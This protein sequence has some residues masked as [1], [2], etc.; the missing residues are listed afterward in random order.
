MKSCIYSYPSLFLHSGAAA[1]SWYAAADGSR[2]RGRGRLHRGEA[3]G[4]PRHPGHRSQDPGARALLSGPQPM[5]DGIWN[6]ALKPF[7]Y[8]PSLQL[9]EILLLVQNYGWM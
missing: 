6:I 1:D 4:R 9:D 7:H 3:G 2:R 5:N 8:V